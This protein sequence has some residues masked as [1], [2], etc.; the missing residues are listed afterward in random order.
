MAE[1]KPPEQPADDVGGVLVPLGLLRRLLNYPLSIGLVLEVA[2]LGTIPYLILGAIVSVLSG[3]SWRQ[4]AIEHG[5]DAL[6]ALVVSV[7]CWP[8][9]LLV[10]SCV[11]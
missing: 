1:N 2:L 3:S 5:G 10:H 6:E 4:V 9:L 8:V 11:T 7:V